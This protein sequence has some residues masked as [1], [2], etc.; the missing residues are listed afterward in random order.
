MQLYN[1]ANQ[2]LFDINVAKCFA[3]GGEGSICEHPKDKTKV[4]KVYHKSRNLKLEQ[5]LLELNKLGTEFV[6]PEEIYYTAHGEIAGFSMKYVDMTKY[7]VLKKIFNNT[8]C[9]QNGFDKKIK[10]KIYQNLTAAIKHTHSLGIVIGDLNPYN[11]LVNNTGEIVLLDVDSFGTKTNPHNGVL[12]EDIRDWDNHPNVSEKTDYFAFDVLTF[13]MF[14]FLHPFR[15]DYPAHKTIEERVCKKSSVLSNLPITIPKCYQPFTNHIIV[16]QFKQV[17][18]DGLRFIVDLSGQPQI[19]QISEISQPAIVQSN[20]LFIR[21]LDTGI[22]KLSISD[23]FIAYLKDGL[24]NI[25][26]VRDFGVYNKLY[27]ISDAENVFVGLKNVVYQKLNYLWC[28]SRQLKNISNTHGLNCVA[29]NNSIFMTSNMLDKYEAL[30]VDDILNDS[31]LSTQSNI[32]VKSL[33]FGEGGIWQN[34]GDKKWLLDLTKNQ[35][36]IIKTTFNIKNIYKRRGYVL[37]EHLD[38]NKTRYTMCRINGLN[39][40]IGCDL[41]E[42]RYFDVKQGFVFIPEDGKINLINPTNNWKIVST[43]ECSICAFDSRIYHTNAG[44]VIQ[45]GNSIYLINKK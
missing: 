3:S 11:I 5:S 36:N 13:W 26:S 23:N 42:W 29:D 35:F 18:Q 45:S 2:L 9:I 44:M 6:K 41:P 14:T 8:F 4:V 24:W 19:L 21:Q 7:V 31:I 34:I 25:L 20:E 32:F 27:T 30:S 38:S 40:E 43:I 22:A 10:Y 16:D 17:F 33:Q 28:E 37:I 15:G 39:L 12:L 1:K